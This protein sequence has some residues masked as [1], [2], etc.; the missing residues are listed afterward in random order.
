MWFFVYLFCEHATYV[1]VLG[2]GEVV[3]AVVEA[4]AVMQVVVA[5]EL[6]L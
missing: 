6:E 3:V 5:V 1:S 2:L 4:E